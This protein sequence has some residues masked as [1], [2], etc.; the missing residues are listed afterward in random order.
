M[1]GIEETESLSFK[2]DLLTCLCFWAKYLIYTRKLIVKLKTTVT[3]A[4]I[5]ALTPASREV[6]DGEGF[7]PVSRRD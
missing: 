6:V 3:S 2:I 5:V 4:A 7:R 1:A